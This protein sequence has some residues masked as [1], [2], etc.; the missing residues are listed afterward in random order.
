M[1]RIVTIRSVSMIGALEYICEELEGTGIANESEA[2]GVRQDSADY[3]GCRACVKSKI[4]HRF[5]CDTASSC[6]D[7]VEEMEQGIFCS[8][9]DTI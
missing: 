6:H 1:P 8:N 4:I 7:K 5:H 9:R 3:G 2:G